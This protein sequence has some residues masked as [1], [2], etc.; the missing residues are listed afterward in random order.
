VTRSHPPEHLVTLVALAFAVAACDAGTAPRSVTGRWTGSTIASNSLFA[1]QADI[2]DAGGTLAGTSS[3]MG[4][5]DGCVD[6]TFQVT[7]TRSG[8]AV[9]LTFTCENYTPFTFDATLAKN[10]RT[11]QGTLNGSG[12]DGAALSL[13]RDR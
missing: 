8:S 9:S 4:S 10:G 6:A 7:G 3:L 1:F 12:F 2:V 5:G 11:L 13:S